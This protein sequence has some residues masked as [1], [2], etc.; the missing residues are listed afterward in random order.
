MSSATLLL[1]CRQ[2]L[3]L[4]TCCRS[5][6]RQELEEMAEALEEAAAAFE[7]AADEKEGGAWDPEAAAMESTMM[8]MEQEKAKAEAVSACCDVRYIH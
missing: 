6:R 2:V 5:P 4:A 3:P 1:P 7:E 8:G